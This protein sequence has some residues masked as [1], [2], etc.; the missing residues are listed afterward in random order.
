MCDNSVTACFL[1]KGRSKCLT[2]MIRMRTLTW[3]AAVNNVPFFAQQ[4]PSKENAIA[5]SLSR[6][7]LQTFHKLQSG[8]CLAPE[9][10]LWDYKT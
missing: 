10:I 7:I 6:F 8:V 2:I 1:H 9:L 5:D 3:A 4:L